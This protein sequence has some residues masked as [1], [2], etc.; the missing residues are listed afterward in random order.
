[1]KQNGHARYYDR[2]T[3]EERFRL[4]V[5]AMSRGDAQESEL[6]VRSCP[7]LQ[8]TMNHRGFTGRWLGVMDIT[9]RMYVDVAGYLDRIKAMEMVR[10]I[11]PYSET[12]AGDRALDTYLEGHQAGAR[13]AWREAG[14]EGDAPEWPLEGVDEA[15]I[16]EK[17]KSAM[18]I[19]PETLKKLERDQAAHALTLW[20]GFEAFCERSIGLDAA[21]VLKVVLE[22]GVERIEELEDL[23]QRLGLEPEP[24]TVEEIAR[25]L[26]EG[27]R[28]VEQAG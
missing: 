23:A 21:A 9:L 14:K 18:S 6:L 7:R 11:H 15:G 17:L 1:M 13:Q 27:W 19:L 3:P 22:P 4:D 16:Y 25:G 20:R 10:V 12:F 24:E 26:A 2:L 5:L 28:V 8:Y